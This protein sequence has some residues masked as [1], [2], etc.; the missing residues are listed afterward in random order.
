MQM[1]AGLSQEVGCRL[2]PLRLAPVYH[3]RCGPCEVTDVPGKAAACL[4]G[5]FSLFRPALLGY[6]KAG[7]KRWK[8]AVH[9]CGR[10]GRRLRSSVTRAFLTSSSTLAHIPAPSSW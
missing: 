7:C 3:P 6:R 4:G 10:H 9:F 8:Q 2:S 1:A 5:A